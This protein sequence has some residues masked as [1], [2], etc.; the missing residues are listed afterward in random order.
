MRVSTKKACDASSIYKKALLVIDELRI[1]KQGGLKTVLHSRLKNN[2]TV[3]NLYSVCTEQE[4][5]QF[6]KLY[7]SNGYEMDDAAFMESRY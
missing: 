4:I 2:I 6:H 3:K 1:M 7:H 5:E